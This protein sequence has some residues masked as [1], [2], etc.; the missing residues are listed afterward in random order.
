L[1][2]RKRRGGRAGY[3]VDVDRTRRPAIAVATL[4]AAIAVVFLRRPDSL[5][6]A[7][8]W[9]E[10]GRVFFADAYNLGGLAALPL[11]YNG[12]LNLF[13]R[14]LAALAAPWPLAHAPLVMN[15]GAIA[16]Q[17]LP[18]LVLSSRRLAADFPAL[19]ARIA[20]ALLYLAG[21]GVVGE[22][23][24]SATN[25]QW[26]LAVLAWC[27]VV[28]QRPRGDHRAWLDAAAVAVSALSGP[29]ALFLLPIAVAATWTRQRRLLTLANGALLA[30][31]VIQGT[32]L[33]LSGSRDAV[34]RGASL[35]ALGRVL[36]CQVL[37]GALAGDT[38]CAGDG[39]EAIPAVAIAIAVLALAVTAYTAAKG[40][41][42]A[43]LLLAFAAIVLVATLVSS[44]ASWAE[45]AWPGNGAR[46]WFIPTFA[47][48]AGAVWLWSE[49]ARARQVLGFAALSVAAVGL[50]AGWS[51]PPLADLSY[52]E[53]A[54]WFERQPPGSVAAIRI[55][56]AHPRWEMILSKR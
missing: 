27:L 6:N 25:S 15:A 53:A 13:P 50:V 54:A 30:G 12:Y 29:F 35:D 9:A 21:P 32:V 56:P 7:Q 39:G 11:P 4:V 26:H 45:L 2:P 28:A 40:P 22:V 20:L 19:R 49:A 46:Y 44:V 18:A 5:L 8:F 48:G 38:A 55:N 3:G 43:R 16:I 52:G 24:A 14:A 34:A 42:A 33:L 51:Q 17:A 31:A 41:P 47:V 10:D 1:T 23:N 36:S 37:A